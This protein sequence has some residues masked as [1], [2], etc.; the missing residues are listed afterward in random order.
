MCPKTAVGISPAIRT[1]RAISPDPES[2]SRDECRFGSVASFFRYGTRACSQFASRSVRG[3]IR[4]QQNDPW[5]PVTLIS[6]QRGDKIGGQQ[7]FWR[8]DSD[9]F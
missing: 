4:E 1:L 7:E 3:G 5:L 6:A 2:H 8:S 9:S